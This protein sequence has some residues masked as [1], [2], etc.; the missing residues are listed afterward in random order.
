MCCVRFLKRADCGEISFLG[1][2][3]TL[4]DKLYFDGKV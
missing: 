3:G 1:A 2:T 4:F